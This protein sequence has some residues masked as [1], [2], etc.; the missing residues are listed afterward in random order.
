MILT[1]S[2]ETQFTPHPEGIFPAVC[3]DLVD[4]GMQTDT[5]NGRTSTRHKI[6]LVFETEELAQD[7][8]RMTVFKTFTASLHEK[9]T[10]GQFVAKWRGRP[11]AIG[12]SIDLSKLV[13]ANCTLVISHATSAKGRTYATIDAVSKPT[14]KL[15]VSADYNP[16]ETRKRIAERAAGGPVAAQSNPAPAPAAKG[17]AQPAPTKSQPAEDNVPF[18]P[19]VG[20]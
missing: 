5:M 2:N 12:E 16:A 15:Q 10:L 8:K 18:D 1:A 14:K 3:C 11:I 4:L 20:F 9:S 13:G 17:V 6:Q 7:G 19:E